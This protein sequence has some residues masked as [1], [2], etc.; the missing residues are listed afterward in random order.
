MRIARLGERRDRSTPLR[1]IAGR[2][3]TGVGVL[4]ELQELPGGQAGRVVDDV[5]VEI[6]D[7]VGATGIAQGIAGDRRRVS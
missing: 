7:L 6:V 2:D 1:P 5:A 4:G 3:A